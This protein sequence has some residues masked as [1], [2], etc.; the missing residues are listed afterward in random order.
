MKTNLKTGMLLRIPT[1]RRIAPPP[2]LLNQVHLSLDAKDICDLES[3]L[4]FTASEANPE[5]FRK[6]AVALI[7][8]LRS[9][10]GYHVM[11]FGSEVDGSKEGFCQCE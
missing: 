11:Q 8:L 5:P 4:F 10:P 7:K 1:K 2:Q 6:K 9:N 3:C